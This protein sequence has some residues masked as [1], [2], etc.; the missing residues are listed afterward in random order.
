MSRLETIAV[1]ALAA[2]PEAAPAG[3]GA[4]PAVKGVAEGWLVR[5]A[6][7]QPAA[8]PALSLPHRGIAAPPE[9]AQCHLPLPGYQA[10][11]TVRAEA[12]GY[13]RR[14][15]RDDGR[16]IQKGSVV[17]LVARRPQG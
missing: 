11:A 4:P 13:Q 17:N 15:M 2:T 16:R 3:V 12:R 9:R 6:L 5:E 8:L 10:G 14:H 1:P 7:G